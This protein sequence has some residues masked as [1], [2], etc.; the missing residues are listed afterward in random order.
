MASNAS[1]NAAKT[2]AV[3]GDKALAAQQAGY[4]QQRNDFQPYQQ[5]GVA[6]LGR[7]GQTAGTYQGG[8]PQPPSQMP[9]QGPPQGLGQLGQPPQMGMGGPGGPQG[10][11]LVQVR[12]P[13]GE[14]A[15]LPQAQAQAAVAKGATIV[16]QGGQ[17][18][19]PQGQV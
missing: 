11:A 6:A 2:Q 16:G 14:M 19:M 15:M 13:T 4:T 5:A 3:A 12:A 9:P 1:K 8:P 18:G 7:L 10:G 17:P